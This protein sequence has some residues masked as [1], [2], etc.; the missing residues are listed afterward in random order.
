MDDQSD[1][2]E[3]LIAGM[4]GQFLDTAADRV[5]VIA[6]EASALGISSDPSTSLTRLIRE[7]HTLKGGGATF[8]CS[9]LGDAGG[10]VEQIGKAVLARGLPLSDLEPLY[11]AV[12]LLKD[13][14]AGLR[15][16]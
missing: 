15:Q 8:D 16:A 14:L 10:R 9:S 5:A 12:A 4:R 3:A 13:V 6:A 11:R 2:F 7:A 1:D